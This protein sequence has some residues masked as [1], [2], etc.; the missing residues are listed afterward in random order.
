MVFSHITQAVRYRIHLSWVLGLNSNV[1]KF[2]HDSP[3]LD[4]DC[5]VFVLWLCLLASSEA[6]DKAK[7]EIPP[8]TGLPSLD[9]IPSVAD[10]AASMAKKKE[11]KRIL[12]EKKKEEERR[13][14]SVHVY[15]EQLTMLS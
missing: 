13:V 3:L 10:L 8:Y 7:P 4:I 6:S 2:C 12:E 11:E 9:N 1:P 5:T 15:G 14:S